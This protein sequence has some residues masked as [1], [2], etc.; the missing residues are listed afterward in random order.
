MERIFSFLGGFLLS[1]VIFAVTGIFVGY[2]LGHSGQP[3]VLVRNLTTETIPRVAIETDVGESYSL[4]DVPP[5]G[6]RRIEIS[7]RDK[8]LWITAT[9]ATGEIITSERIYVTS[10]GNVFG[11]VTEDTI[12][13]DYEL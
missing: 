13:I 9:A 2:V 4:A 1:A 6:F 11:M 8:A 3:S 12:T 10:R 5:K 7:G